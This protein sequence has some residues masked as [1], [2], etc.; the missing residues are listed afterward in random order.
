[1]IIS[2]SVVYAIVLGWPEDDTVKVSS[3]IADSAKTKI[4]LLGFDS[5]AD[6]SFD[7]DSETQEL[8]VHFPLMS[9]VVSGCPKVGGCDWGY[10]LKMEGLVNADEK[11]GEHENRIKISLQ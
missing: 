9:K 4:S 11:E 1:M 10:V 5:S 7:V 8:S 3:P 6:L 2:S